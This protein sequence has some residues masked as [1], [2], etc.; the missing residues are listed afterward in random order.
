MCHSGSDK[1]APGTFSYVGGQSPTW[2]YGE[3]LTGC[4]QCVHMEL[5][6]QGWGDGPLISQGSLG[7]GSLHASNLAMLEKWWWRFHSKDNTLWKNI[8]I[9]IHGDYG[10]LGLDRNSIGISFSP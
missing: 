7:V 8:I 2:Q 9:S 3:L 6:L 10:G 5:E 4:R 1:W